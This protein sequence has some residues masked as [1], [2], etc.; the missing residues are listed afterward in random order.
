MSWQNA[1]LRLS[2]GLRILVFVG[3]LSDLL[4]FFSFCLRLSAADLHVDEMV[5]LLQFFP[6]EPFVGIDKQTCNSFVD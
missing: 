3:F 1:A 5:D 6:L 4:Q 2:L